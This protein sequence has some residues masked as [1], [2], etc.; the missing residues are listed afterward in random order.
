[1][2]RG[3]SG[4]APDG[5]GCASCYGADPD[6]TWSYYCAQG[7]IV[8]REIRDDPH[9]VVQLRRCTTCTQQF[10]WLLTEFVDWQRGDDAQYRTVV[11]VTAG[12]ARKIAERGVDLDRELLEA[13]GETRRYLQA[14]SP[15]GARE[16]TV[17]WSTG[18]LGISAGH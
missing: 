2:R 9:F 16:A 12:E 3:E 7:L 1:M 15:T 5:L 8:V 10:L 13:L 6:E 18:R 17:K 4:A 14:D 11:P